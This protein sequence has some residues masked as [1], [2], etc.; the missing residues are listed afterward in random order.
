MKLL[1]FDSETNGLPKDYRASYEDVDNWPRVFS[2]AWI[3]ANIDG[4]IISQGN[5]IVKPDGWTIPKE[6]LWLDNGY[7]TE[8]CEA[9]GVP[10]ADVLDQF[11][12]AKHEASVLV[13]HNLNFDHRIVW[14][15]IIRSGRTPRSGMTKFCTM[16][17][18]TSICRIPNTGRGGFK[19]PKLEELY[20]FLFQKKFDAAHTAMADVIACMESFFE[21]HRRGLITMEMPAA[22]Q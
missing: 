20:E 9:N 18:T 5:F 1:F 4:S 11:I 22:A 17:K 16:M 3:L 10:I 12:A 14:A 8:F 6:K 15:E 13:A 7:T 21:L 2:L 19:W